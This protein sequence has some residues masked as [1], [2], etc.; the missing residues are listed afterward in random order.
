MYHSLWVRKTTTEDVIR[1]PSRTQ[2]FILSGLFPSVLSLTAQTLEA[3][4][5]QPYGNLNVIVS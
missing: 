5:T 4:V 3:E 2:G 1:I